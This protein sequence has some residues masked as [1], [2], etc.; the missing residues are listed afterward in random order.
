MLRNKIIPFSKRWAKM[1]KKEKKRLK[2]ALISRLIN[3][4]TINSALICFRSNMR[5]I[6]QGMI[7][8]KSILCR[9]RAWCITSSKNSKRTKVAAS[10]LVGDTTLE[11]VPQR[12][13]SIDLQ[14]VQILLKLPGVKLRVTTYNWRSQK[15]SRK[16]LKDAER[17]DFKK[18]SLIHLKLAW[19]L[20]LIFN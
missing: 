6:I 11:F 3:H 1:K 4:L 7:K 12:R 5:R 13:E 15:P 19:T 18:L 9:V 14:R 20:L 17:S 2:K 16:E 8:G 10:V